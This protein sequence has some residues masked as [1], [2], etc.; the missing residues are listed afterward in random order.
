MS[1]L[2]AALLTAAL[3]LPQPAAPGRRI[4]VT[5][6]DLPTVSALGPGIEHSERLTRDLLAALRRHKVPAIGFVNEGK[7]NANGA[8]DPARVALLQHWIDA[9]LELGNHTYAHTDL[10]TAPIEEFERGVVAGEQ[11]TKALLRK[12]GRPVRYFRHPYLHSGRDR[13]TRERL[14]KFLAARGYRVAPVTIDNGDYIFASAYVRVAE[15]DRPKVLAEYLD[16]MEGVVAFYEQQSVA[17]VGR[18]IAHTLLIHAN[19]LNAAAFD[20]LA[21]R[22]KKRGY[23][24][25]TLDEA[26]EDPVYQSPDDYFGPAG[27]SWLHRW[28]MTAGKPSSI[29]KGEPAVPEWIN[30][31]A[32]RRG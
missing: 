10:H 24:F 29:F 17:I 30:Q 31:A 8:L 28:A 18:E 6:D 27:I 4:A 7:L 16:Y 12:A 5:I 13:D 20:D 14:E 25:I 1:R 23:Q 21:G 3:A 15:A 2:F 11:V 22:L 19:A 26:L 9:G 32:A